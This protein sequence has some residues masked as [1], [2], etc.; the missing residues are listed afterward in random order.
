MNKYPLI[1]LWADAFGGT[2]RTDRP[3]PKTVSKQSR[4]AAQKAIMKAKEKRAR[5]NA[6]RAVTSGV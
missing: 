1:R 2:N 4:E 5:K 6:A 3:A